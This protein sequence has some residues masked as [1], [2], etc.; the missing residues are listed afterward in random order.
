MIIGALLPHS[1]DFQNQIVDFKKIS[2]FLVCIYALLFLIF[3]G[4]VLFEL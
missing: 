4:E 2:L 3:K 1:V